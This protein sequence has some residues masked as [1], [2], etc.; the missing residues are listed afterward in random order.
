MG[1]IV[2]IAK[3]L[4]KRVDV[5][6][7]I[8]L[9][10]L[11]ML[12]YNPFALFDTGLLLSYGGT[13]GI[14]IFINF[15]K[16]AKKYILKIIAT[17]LSAQIIIIPIIA[18]LFCK[19]H[20][21]FLVSSIIATPIFE[22]IILI[23]FIFVIASY[24]C[25]PVCLILKIPLE[26]CLTFFLNTAQIV[27]NLPFAQINIAKPSISVIIIYYF[28]I[29]IML[30]KRIKLPKKKIIAILICIVMILQITKFFPSEL[31]IYF[32]DVGQGDCTLIETENHKTIM[33][34][35][36]GTENLEEYDIGKNILVPY[37]YARGITKLDYI[38]ISHFHADHCNRIYCSNE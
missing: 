25:P 23:G 19:I 32:I 27:S 29:T 15:F 24:I 4:F 22:I 7:T 35:S 1:A 3:L 6:N 21:S 34:D 36:G 16:W 20:L 30:I 17:S 38:M 37:L 5:A 2:I 9:S 13:I 10:L 18:Y 26:I 8:S 11:L 33:I 31:C 14:I 28:A 12:L